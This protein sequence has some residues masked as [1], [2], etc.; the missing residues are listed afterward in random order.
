MFDDQLPGEP[1]IAAREWVIGAPRAGAERARGV[2]QK[3]G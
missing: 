3:W 1:L 2:F